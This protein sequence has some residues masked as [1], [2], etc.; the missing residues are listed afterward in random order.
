MRAEIKP[1]SG[2]TGEKI[3]SAIRKRKDK[4]PSRN[5]FTNRPSCKTLR[6]HENCDFEKFVCEISDFA[7]RSKKIKW[8]AS[9]TRT[10]KTSARYL[11]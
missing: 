11:V 5:Q 8:F 2:R 4:F 7:L 9:F 10:S 6:Q 3:S 1:A